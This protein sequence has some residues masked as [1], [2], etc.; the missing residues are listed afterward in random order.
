MTAC[1]IEMHGDGSEGHSDRSLHRSLRHAEQP[2]ATA[3]NAVVGSAN[4][5][6]RTFSGAE[7]RETLRALAHEDDWFPSGGAACALLTCQGSMTTEGDLANVLLTTAADR[8]WPAADVSPYL[9][10]DPSLFTGRAWTQQDRQSLLKLGRSQDK[11][12]SNKV[13]QLHRPTP[14]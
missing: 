10:T 9:D 1:R 4:G 12:C 2:L 14:T 3:R 7:I 8:C 5:H 11:V 13:Q 6:G